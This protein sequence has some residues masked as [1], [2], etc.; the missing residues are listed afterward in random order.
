MV[1]LPLLILNGRKFRAVEV[2]AFPF[3]LIS[4]CLGKKKNKNKKNREGKDLDKTCLNDCHE[5]K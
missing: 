4:T 5:K 2:V 3:P 1:L